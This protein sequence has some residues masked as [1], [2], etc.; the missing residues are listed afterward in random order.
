MSQV[1]KCHQYISQQTDS[2]LIYTLGISDYGYVALTTVQLHWTADWYCQKHIR[3]DQEFLSSNNN[4]SHKTRYVCETK[5]FQR[6][7][8]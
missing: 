8:D 6:L 1:L 3:K 5:C 4:N 7:R 2:S